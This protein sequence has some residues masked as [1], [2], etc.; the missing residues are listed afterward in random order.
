MASL[1]AL[2]PEREGRKRKKKRWE[3][4]EKG[5]LILLWFVGGL[6]SKN[7]AAWSLVV[8]VGRSISKCVCCSFFDHFHSL[9]F[10]S[11]FGFLSTIRLGCVGS[12]KGRLIWRTFSLL[13]KIRSY[14]GGPW[15][16][17][18]SLK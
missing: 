5:K 16:D 17:S 4:F 7:R 14:L 8:L 10:S 11:L 18:S 6:K 12:F 3:M 13:F 1:R 2:H 9:L 15:F